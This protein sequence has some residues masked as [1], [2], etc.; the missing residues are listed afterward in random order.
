MPTF[1]QY[2][3]YYDLIYQDKDYQHESECITQLIHAHSS[4][5]K[6]ILELGCGTGRHASYMA[7]QFKIYAI[8]TS[9]EM[10]NCASQY[11]SQGIHFER[12]DV[13]NYRLNQ[14]V[15]TVI[16]MFHVASYQVRMQDLMDY[17]QT[18]RLHLDTGGIF[19]FDCWYGPA[20]LSQQPEVR[21]K[22][23]ENNRFKI[24]RKAQP[25][26]DH[27]HNTVSVVYDI[28]VMNKETQQKQSFA[29]THIMRY[30]FMSEIESLAHQNQFK[31]LDVKEWLTNKQPSL[32]TWSV[33]F[34]LVAI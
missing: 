34:V 8:D 21:T 22:V 32:N 29:E 31:V 28:G 4:A 2:S 9:Q 10:L 27:L 14:T 18:A 12:G 11:A 7:Q 3:E 6:T 33:Y 17:F 24:T 20:V 26:L 16:S 13:R 30:L 15:D 23:V 5:C 1:N 19:I 25:N